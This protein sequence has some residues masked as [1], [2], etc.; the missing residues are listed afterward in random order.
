MEKNIPSV[1]DFD[2]LFDKGEIFID[3]SEAKVIRS[4]QRRFFRYFTGILSVLF[5]SISLLSFWFFYE[6]YWRWRDCFNEEGSCFVPSQS[7]VYHDSSVFWLLPF[8]IFLLLAF[9]NLFFF[10][11]LESSRYLLHLL[12]KY[13]GKID[14][15]EDTA[16]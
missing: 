13:R 10:Y 4:T 2:E 9:V 3:F 6:F 11:R 8:G 1:D 15:R 14:F 12:R 7:V 16:L 5:F